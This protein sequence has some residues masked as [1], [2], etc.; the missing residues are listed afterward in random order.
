MNKWWIISVFIFV[1]SALPVNAQNRHLKCMDIPIDGSFDE[2]E[3]KFYNYDE[4]FVTV[5]E[6]RT[7]RGP[8]Y[9]KYAFVKFIGP[10]DCI[11]GVQLEIDTVFNTI[12]QARRLQETYEKRFRERYWSVFSEGTLSHYDDV[13]TD[14]GITDSHYCNIKT[15]GGALLGQIYVFIM[16]YYGDHSK[17]QVYITYVDNENRKASTKYALSKKTYFLLDDDNGDVLSIREAMKIVAFRRHF[18]MADGEAE[19]SFINSVLKKHSY[20]EQEFLEGVGTCSFWQFTKYGHAKFDNQPDDAF[21]PDNPLLA[22]NVAVVDCDGIETIEND[23]TSIAVDIRVYGDAQKEMLMNEMREIGFMPIKSDQW[24]KEYGWKS[25][26]IRIHPGTSRG[27][28][29]CEFNVSLELIDY[30]STKN[31]CF[32]DSSSFHKIQMNVDYLV[33]GNQRLK[34]NVDAFIKEAFNIWISEVDDEFKGDIEDWSSFQRVINFYGKRDAKRLISLEYPA[35]AT[36]SLDVHKIAETDKYITF[37]VRKCGFY[38]GVVSYQI[39]GATFRKSDGK[40]MKIIQSPQSPQFKSFLNENIL[41]RLEKGGLFQEY[42]NSLPYPQY[43][44]YLIQTG[45]R[46]V[47]QKYEI[48]GGAMG[49]I[50]EDETFLSVKD[51]ITDEVRELL[52][53]NNVE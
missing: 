4:G 48:G 50:K 30:G 49:Y 45:V 8:Y 31:Y 3:Q 24:G 41:P 38:G 16:R 37:E 22:S 20:Q 7:L 23:E 13:V 1:F 29:Y 52:V 43:E 47:Y 42:R 9:D 27:Y 17:Y 35:Q 5:A 14:W 12:D 40:R 32:A 53:D 6:D 18:P 10:D 2:M 36:E 51:Y 28:N 15:T 34:Q 46:F 19:T 11:W 26:R 39:Y 25:Y 44:P 21:V 33:N